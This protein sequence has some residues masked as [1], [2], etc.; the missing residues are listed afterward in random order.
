MIRF[1]TYQRTPRTTLNLTA[2]VGGHQSEQ[3]AYFLTH[4]TAFAALIITGFFPLLAAAQPKPESARESPGRLEVYP[5]TIELTGTRDFQHIVVRSISEDGIT[6]DVT[7]AATIVCSDTNIV[8]LSK[9][10]VRAWGNGESHLAITYDGQTVKMPVNVTKIDHHRDVSLR[11]DVIPT[12]TSA[13]CN[14]GSCHGSARGQDGFHL[15]LF[16][17]DPNGD[18]YAMTRELPGRRLNFAQ[19]AE[20]LLVKKAVGRAPHTGG[21]LFD[22]DSTHAETLIEWI[23]RGAPN[24]P[25]DIAHVTHIDVYPQ[26]MVLTAGGDAQRMIVRSYYSDGT[27]RD[28]TE[29]AALMSNN[30]VC[31]R[32]DGSG[33]VTPGQRGEAQLLARFDVHSVGIPVIVIPADAPNITPPQPINYIDELVHQKLMKLRIQPSDVCADDV[34]LR[35]A[36]ID[37]VGMLPTTDAHAAFIADQRPDKRAQLI[38]E[39]LQRKEFVELWVMQWAERMQIR[40]TLEVSYKAMLLYYNWL[41]ERLA[42]DMP[43]NELIRELLSAT[44]GTFTSPATNFYQL[45]RD[46]LKLSENVAQ[47]FLGTRIQCAQCHNHP[48]D[49]WTMDD[50]YSF[51]AFFAQVGRK[52]AEDPR[53]TIV[54]NNRN[55]EVK[56]PVDNR[57]M[58]PRFLGGPKPG[59]KG[60]DRRVVLAEWLTSNDN[61]MFAKNVANMVWAHF[62]GRGIVDPVDD[63]RVSNPPSNG[64]LLDMLAERLVSYNYDLRRFVRDICNSRTYQL[65]STTNPSN[66]EDRRNFSHAAIRRI[67]SEVLLDCIS[68][69]TNAP[70]KFKG[71]P[72]GARAVQIADGNVSNYFL[73]TFGRAKRETICTCE[74]VM[75]PN[76][77]QALHLIN[78]DSINQKIKIGGLV[79]QLIDTGKTPDAI[80]DHLYISCLSRAPTETERDI[81]SEILSTT[82]DRQTALDDLFW[83]LLN[84]K[85]FMFNH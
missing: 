37:L 3:R 34:F 10:R 53:E 51:A 47:S 6:R 50:Y 60:R 18:H 43:L 66:A 55:G 62:F 77:S 83:A 70:N 5:P 58:Q 75:E 16:G 72:L 19:P 68:Q 32:V 46:T 76:L 59:L 78:G 41:Q 26:D 2:P 79:K 82:D 38:D 44:G 14:N 11:L 25:S 4:R 67:R 65:S 8:F 27:T 80:V 81:V 45:E 48:F 64:P 1:N 12:L 54:F 21:K 33:R 23:E 52:R 49:R 31:T 22:R 24:D 35:R 84:S 20:S 71:L 17:Y 56:H 61:D 15:S 29:L 36:Y 63:V 40:S 85:E 9:H 13:G 42:A 28:V 74:V 69:V 30:D 57:V 39:L 73:A 7:N